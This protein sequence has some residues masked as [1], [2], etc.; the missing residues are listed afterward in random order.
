MENIFGQ[1]EV[2]MKDNLKIIKLIGM[3]NMFTPMEIVMK[4]ELKI[5]CRKEVEYIKW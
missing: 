2:G 5:I 1:M 3:E 4:G